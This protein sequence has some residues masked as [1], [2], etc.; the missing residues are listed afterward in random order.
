ME[1]SQTIST[2]QPI[3]PS[4]LA[5]RWSRSTLPCSLVVQNA[6][7]VDGVAE[8]RIR[9]KLRDGCT[10]EVADQKVLICANGDSAA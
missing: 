5:A 4:L 2:R 6:V 1:H 7:R 9:R 8:T 10:V 3:S